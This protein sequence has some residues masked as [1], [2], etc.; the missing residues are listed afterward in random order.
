MSKVD[1]RHVLELR[2]NAKERNVRNYG[3]LRIKFVLL[4]SVHCI[5]KCKIF[6]FDLIRFSGLVPR[7]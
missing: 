2:M 4:Q 5:T 7:S 1:V 6:S 3:I